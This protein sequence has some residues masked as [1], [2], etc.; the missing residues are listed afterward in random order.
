MVG[1]AT[2]T[3]IDWS[4]TVTASNGESYNLKITETDLAGNVSAPKAYLAGAGDA[5]I[6]LGV[7]KAG[8]DYGQLIAPVQVDGGKWFYHWYRNGNNVADGA[9]VMS[10]FEI[11]G[12][13]N[14]GSNG[15]QG[16][17]TTDTVR[18]A[19]ING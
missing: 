4:Y 13:F 6:D 5:V 7:D 2:V 1:L 15:V 11:N 3:G 19:T 18:F 17:G 14:Y 10:R 8:V 16:S 12:I 9:D